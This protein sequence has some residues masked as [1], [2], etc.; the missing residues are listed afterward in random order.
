VSASSCTPTPLD[1]ELQSTAHTSISIFPQGDRLSL[2]ISGYKSILELPVLQANTTSVEVD[3][4]EDYKDEDVPYEYGAGAWADMVPK[5]E[6][7]PAKR[8]CTTDKATAVSLISNRHV[9]LLTTF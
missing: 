9:H 6:K 4:D 8:P 1:A 7:P 2:N 5:P 3:R